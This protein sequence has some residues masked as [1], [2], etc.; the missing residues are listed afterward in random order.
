M[1]DPIAD[2]LTRIRNA[3]RALLPEIA[4]PH[5]KLKESIARLLQH[6]GYVN[7]VSI[8]GAK[9]EKKIKIKLKYTGRKPVIEGL[10]RVSTPGLRR[11]SGSEKLPRVLG[12]LGTVIVS[13]SQGIMTGTQARKKNVGGEVLCFVW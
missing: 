13:T 9:I 11:Y 8:E 12:G 10:K 4:V 2:L 5:S 7:S 3:S 6:E 1:T